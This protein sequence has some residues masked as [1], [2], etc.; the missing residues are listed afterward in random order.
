MQIILMIC[1]CIIALAAGVYLY[2]VYTAGRVQTANQEAV[3]RALNLGGDPETFW[4]NILVKAKA[5][6]PAEKYETFQSAVLEFVG[7]INT[8]NR[9]GLKNQSEKSA[10]LEKLARASHNPEMSSIVAEVFSK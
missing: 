3:E 1:I 10:L 9:S 2:K 4:V 6:M 8:V 7:Y 5:Q